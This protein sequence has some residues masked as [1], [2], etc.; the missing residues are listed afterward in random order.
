MTSLSIEDLKQ[1]KR[2]V[3]W[4]LEP[5]AD[6][7]VTKVPY[8]PSGYK[9]SITNSAHLRT[10]AELEPHVSKFSGSVLRLVV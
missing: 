4:R 6:S 9:A 8:Q 5:G 3:L 1:Q 2:W 10:Y 7:K